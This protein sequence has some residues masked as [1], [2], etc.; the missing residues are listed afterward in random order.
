MSAARDAIVGSVRRALGRTGPV[1]SAAAK[2]L[3]ARIAEHAPHVQP[4]FGKSPVD[5]FTEKLRALT[6]TLETVQR[7]QI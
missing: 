2:K 3:D 1:D 6:G 5:Q 7:R 4:A